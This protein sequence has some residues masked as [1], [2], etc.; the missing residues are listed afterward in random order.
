LEVEDRIKKFSLLL[1]DNFKKYCLSV[2]EKNI[3]ELKKM[4]KYLSA[5]DIGTDP[6]WE[7]IQL[8]KGTL[9]SKIASYRTAYLSTPS[10][11]GETES[12]AEVKFIEDVS[13]MFSV[14]FVD[15]FKLGYAYLN[16]DLYTKDLNESLKHK[17]EVFEK[18]VVNESIELLC[19]EF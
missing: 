6:A 19:T 14:V 2:E 16:G 11:P 10:K 15:L 4:I 5:L 18:E 8:I 1:H 12:P 9:F 13:K 7:S 3:D 17:A